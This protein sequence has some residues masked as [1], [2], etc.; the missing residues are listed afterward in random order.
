MLTLKS[1]DVFGRSKAYE[2]IIKQEPIVGPKIP[3]S[4]NVLVKELQGLS[5]RVDL[6]NSEVGE[7]DAED[8]LEASTAEDA[9]NAPEGIALDMD[10][11]DVTEEMVASEFEIVDEPVAAVADDDDDDSTDDAD[12]NQQDSKQEEA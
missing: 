8:M 6:M 10:P 1:D 7:I 11:I 9:L 3:E 4:F 12:D 2:S 5:L